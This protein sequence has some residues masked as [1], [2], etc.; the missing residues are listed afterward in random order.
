M[1]KRCR[2]DWWPMGSIRRLAL[3]AGIVVPLVACGSLSDDS[4]SCPRDALQARALADL[5]SFTRWLDRHDVE[6]VVGEVGWPGNR[7]SAR[8]NALGE[9][10][11][12]AAD[13]ADLPVTAWASGEWWPADYPLAVY[14]STDPGKPLNKGG[15]QARV[16][17]AHLQ[18]ARG[19]RGIAEAGGGFGT[20]GGG[21][22]AQQPG[23]YGTDYAYPSARSLR[24]LARRGLSLVRL[25]F[26]WER[27][28]PGLHG[29]LSDEELGRLRSTVAA[30]H[31]AGLRVV[32]DLHNYGRYRTVAS[33]GS[34][35][36]RVLGT[37][38]LPASDLA[39][40]WRRLTEAFKGEPGIW[41]YGLMNEPHDLPGPRAG[42]D[43]WEQASQEAV[44]AI[45]GVGDRTQV[46]VA[47]MQWSR[48]A[49]WASTHPRPWITDPARA[50]RYEGHQYFD[51]D[52]SGRYDG[53]YAAALAAARQA[54]AHGGC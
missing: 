45:R 44:D 50:L 37:P 27:I 31:A 42:A 9:A 47:G 46:L 48:V 3:I 17:E 30:A 33:D 10:W 19:N 26:S 51:S 40:V 15:R 6:G 38:E 49:G 39:D 53:G 11:Y 24:F 22:S 12:D 32:L 36:E 43:T 8:W 5:S 1:A 29:P 21:Y 41:G 23:K 28:Q 13:A 16:V 18:G 14:R 2:V 25:S 54:G 7:D 4:A 35:L 34:V 20:E 52:Y